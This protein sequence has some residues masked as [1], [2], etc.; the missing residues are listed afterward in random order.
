MR[1][2]ARGADVIFRQPRW[3]EENQFDLNPPKMF[4]F[5]EII[6]NILLITHQTQKKLEKENL[7]YIKS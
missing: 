2:K 3:F 6:E 5:F 1:I 7:I 4:I